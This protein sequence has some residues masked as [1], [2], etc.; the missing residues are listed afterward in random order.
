M[1]GQLP[2]SLCTTVAYS[3][4]A[5]FASPTPDTDR[6]AVVL[7]GG[8]RAGSGDFRNTGG[9]AAVAALVGG[10]IDTEVSSLCSSLSLTACFLGNKGALSLAKAVSGCR[11]KLE[12][13]CLENCGIG[14]AGAA[15][16]ALALEEGPTQ[17][18]TPRG[19]TQT[20]YGDHV[21]GINGILTY[22][23]ADRALYINLQCTQY[24]SRST[25]PTRRRR[26]SCLNNPFGT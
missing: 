12:T 25:A 14:N 6:P 16:L 21:V 19:N 5:L 4:H 2:P 8:D 9:A 7:C 26:L 24:T 10:G 11:R 13:L 22:L 3:T 18:R 23:L 15:A 1:K 20:T 17:G